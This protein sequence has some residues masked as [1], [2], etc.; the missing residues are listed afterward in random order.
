MGDNM[1]KM[2]NEIVEKKRDYFYEVT[3]SAI[4][5]LSLVLLGRLGKAGY[6]LYLVF[7]IVFGDFSVI[8]LVIL[9][10]LGLRGLIKKKYVDLRHISVLGFA[11]VYLALAMFCHLALYD[12]LGMTNSNVI[13]K[14]FDLYKHYFTN[15]EI[16][17]VFGGGMFG[18]FFFQIVIILFGKIGLI[19]I[20]LVILFIGI[21]FLFQ[22]HFIELLIKRGYFTKLFKKTIL[23]FF[24]YFSNL[25]KTKNPRV[26]QKT[27]HFG[28]DILSDIKSNQ[29]ILLQEQIN[30]ESK[31]NLFDYIK[32]NK[33]GVTIRSLSTSFSSSRFELGIINR[34][35]V[36][37][38]SEKIILFFNKNCYAFMQD[39]YLY[40]DINNQF[41]ELLTLKR[42]MLDYMEEKFSLGVDV[43][44]K[45][46]EIEMD[47]YNALI[48]IGDYGSGI[49]NA[50]KCFM[51]ECIITLKGLLNI[52][53][54]DYKHEFDEILGL[55]SIGKYC[56]DYEESK[57]LLE[58]YFQEYERRMELFKFL[59]VN[60]L[61]EAN[62][63]IE[64]GHAKLNQL[65]PIYVF[66][67]NG[68]TGMPFELVQKV[69]Y[70]MRFGHNAGI[71]VVIGIRNLDELQ[72]L[73]IQNT[74]I[75]FF[76]TKEI[77]LSL[78]VLGND[79]ACYLQRK[80]DV[81]LMKEG[82][83]IH[84]Q[85]PFISENNYLEVLK[86]AI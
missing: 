27:L 38:I 74:L 3:G 48:F 31:E 78:K 69:N 65:L 10:G 41:R 58:D 57:G 42:M 47:K 1:P 39:N 14:T 53:M 50:F 63:E 28:I 72:K 18:A 29:N 37:Q 19:V 70:L 79:Q 81:V 32:Q 13:S 43:Y 52:M 22:T 6:Y 35:S 12:E 23:G 83:T 55:G 17:Y 46:I 26:K 61:E 64:N 15:Y 9:F 56:N 82:L 62:A 20:S 30:N 60:D 4:V 11:L 75:C 59:N 8:L 66:F 76:Q 73:N 86:K 51:V 49:R 36:K 24:G 2:K 16:S 45:P 67:P 85:I 33:L 71:Y 77:M 44:N 21:S 40:V 84:G 68:F 25:H 80:G 34:E 5:I 54:F 7:R